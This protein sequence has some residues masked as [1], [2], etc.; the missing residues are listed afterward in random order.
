VNFDV[1][2]RKGGRGT[3]SIGAWGILVVP[4]VVTAFS[5]LVAA[6]VDLFGP[7]KDFSDVFTNGN[8]FLV[9]IGAASRFALFLLTSD[10]IL[11]MG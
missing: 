2:R 8:D 3:A 11:A 9:F 4:A 6:L 7:S 10:G 5:T 1:F